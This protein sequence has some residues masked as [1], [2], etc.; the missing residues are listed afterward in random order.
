MNNISWRHH[1]IPQFYL[2]GFASPNGT[3]KIYDVE[4]G[5]YLKNG[6]EFFPEA[7][8]FEKNANTVSKDKEVSDFIE[9]AFK[10]MD[11][12]VAELFNRINSSDSSAA[13]KFKIND[14][15][16]A[17]L[18]YFVGMMYWRIPNNYDEIKDIINKKRLRELGLIIR[19]KDDNSIVEDSPIETQL[20]KDVNLFKFMKLWFPMVSYPEIFDCTT[21]LHLIPLPPGLPAVCG[22][23]PIICTNPN[24][25]R[26][27]SDDYIFPL[28]STKLFIR[29]NEVIDFMS[30][31]KVEIDLL[32][33]KQAKKYVSCT[34]EKYLE[35]LDNMYERSYRNMD[36]LRHS[37]FSQ[38]IGL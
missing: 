10:S 38:I 17:M 4:K 25:F 9:E 13:N 34:D 32:I 3:F 36:D 22:D 15:D 28:N 21:P 31:V 16:I 2:Q 19:K 12:K 20:K 30:S 37:I 5:Y 8:F 7:F 6:K 27:Y 1:Y 11:N 26:V 18:Q 33:F 35:M 23:N 29:G 14:S 24:T